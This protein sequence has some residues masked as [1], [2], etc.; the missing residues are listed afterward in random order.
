MEKEDLKKMRENPNNWIFGLI[1]Y[2]PNDPRTFLPK[3]IK[4]LGFTLNFAKPLSY[5]FVVLLIVLIYLI[6]KYIN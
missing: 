3:R 1:Y 5:L 2:N 6:A 4:W